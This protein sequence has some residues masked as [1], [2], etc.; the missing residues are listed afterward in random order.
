V[1]DETSIAV[2]LAWRTLF[3]GATPT[4][5][6]YE[7]TDPEG[8]ADA[9]DALGITTADVVANSRDDHQPMVLQHRLSDLARAHPTASLCL[10]G[11][12]QTIAALRRHLKEQ[13]L[14]P[15]SLV[16]AYWDNNRTGL[17]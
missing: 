5:E 4:A 11:N 14:L 8:A 6:L 16:K 17:D 3:P 10:T 2:A 9:L 12:A 1:G 15:T 7:A 13:Q